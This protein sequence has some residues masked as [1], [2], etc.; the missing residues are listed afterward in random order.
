MSGQARLY[1][2]DAAR[3]TEQLERM[4]RLEAD[5]VCIFCLEHAAE[6]QREPVEHVGEHWY[7]TRNDFPYEGADAH[8]L[9]VARRH[10]ASFEELPDEAGA[11]LW[12]IRRELAGR[13]DAIALATVERSGDMRFNGGS[14]EH[15]HV[16]MVALGQTPVRTVRFRVSAHGVSSES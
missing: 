13:L 9:I 4:R 11:E 12:A 14:V 10:V 15:L 8:Y 1:N 16:H 2:L 6:E 3:G 5:N 7:V